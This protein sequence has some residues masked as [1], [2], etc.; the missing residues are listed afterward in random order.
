MAPASRID[1]NALP[2]ALEAY[3]RKAVGRGDQPTE[4]DLIRAAKRAGVRP[5]NRKVLSQYRLYYAH[6][7]NLASKRPTPREFATIAIPTLGVVFIDLAFI[8]PQWKGYN[9]GCGGFLVAVEASTQQLAAFP[10]KGKTSDDWRQAV[11]QV[12]DES[13]IPSVKTFVCDREPAVFSKHFR[14]RLR[15]ERG[16]EITF[17][18]RR[19]K[20]YRAESM[21]RWVKVALAR[22]VAQRKANDDPNYRRWVETLPNVV[23]SFNNRKAHD[24]SFR[25]ADIRTNN[26]HEYIN[27]LFQTSDATLLFNSGNLNADRLFST[28]WLQKLFKF[29]V[30]DEVLVHRNATRQ[31]GEV[32]AKA[33]VRG[34]F[35][36]APA[37]VVSRWLK[38]SLKQFLVPG[39]YGRLAALARQPATHCVFGFFLKGWLYNITLFVFLKYCIVRDFV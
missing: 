32:F 22:T 30:G 1:R 39:K 10:M 31:H 27:E 5:P 3:I 20:S 4:N 26:Y 17:L 12:L 15:N 11:L 7:A 33:S 36:D 13:V 16:V 24:T 2:E 19:H 37:R 25:R 23:K 38:R 14:T 35:L 8:Y 29:D 18:T 6:L 9:Q 21:I 28:K 34:S